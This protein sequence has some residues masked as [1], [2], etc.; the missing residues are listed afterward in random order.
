MGVMFIAIAVIS[1]ILLGWFAHCGWIGTKG[2]KDYKYEAKIDGTVR[3]FKFQKF[4][5]E[6]WADGITY[7]YVK[8]EETK[9]AS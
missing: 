4:V 5:T 9:N 6:T 3:Q 1:G 2:V 7:T 8:L